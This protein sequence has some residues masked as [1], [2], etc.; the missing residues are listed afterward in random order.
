MNAD[1]GF[2][3]LLKR[4][5]EADDDEPLMGPIFHGIGS[6]CFVQGYHREAEEC[7]EKSVEI[8]KQPG[9]ER[10]YADTLDNWG[11]LCMNQGEHRLS[12]EKFEKALELHIKTGNRIGRSRTCL[13]LAGTLIELEVGREP[14]Q[15]DYSKAYEKIDEGLA[16]AKEMGNKEG[17]A[18]AYS[19]YGKIHASNN[20]YD[21]AIKMFQNT[22]EIWEQIGYNPGVAMSYSN[23]AA[24]YT[25]KGEAQQA[26]ECYKEAL[27]RTEEIGDKHTSA[28]LYVSQAVLYREHLNDW[29]KAIKQFEKAKAYYDIVGDRQSA[30]EV[31]EELN[32]LNEA[33]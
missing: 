33:V 11:L 29:N 15:R 31:A 25:E 32:L 16:I 2:H 12:I 9:N 13:N 3:S 26:S 22:L 6:I 4:L 24:V 10:Q 5:L 20:H 23:L 30:E 8:S 7:F 28:D 19:R 14:E 18:I 21:D 17:E 1:E 27:R